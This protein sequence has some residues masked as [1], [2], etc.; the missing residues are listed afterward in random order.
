MANELA[1]KIIQREEKLRSERFNWN[2][3]LQEVSE[4]VLPNRA[5]FTTTI[6]PADNTHHKVFDTT[7]IWANEQLAA[8]LHGF[9]T[10]STQRW[11]KMDLNNEE[12]MEDDEVVNWLA[13]ASDVAYKYIYQ[14]NSNFVSMSHEMYLDLGC[15]GTSVMYIEERPSRLSPLRFHTF[16]LAECVFDEDA[17]GQVNTLYRKFKWSVR[18]I[19][20]KFPDTAPK[21]LHEMVEK[22]QNEEMEI[23]LCVKPTEDSKKQALG[24]AF[25]SVYVLVAEKV[26]LSDKAFYEF[27]FAVPRW[28]KL[29][30]EKMGRSPAMNCLYDI[31]M[32]NEMSKTVL[33]SAQK[34]V[35]PPLM[36]PDEG[37]L[38]PIKTTPGGL[39]YYEA[40]R[41]DRIEPLQTGGDVG[42]GLEM[43]NQRREQILRAFYLDSMKLQKENKEM[44]AY[45]AAQRTEENMR[46]MSPMVS[47]L[48]NEA[49]D[50][51]IGRTISI[52][53]RLQLLPPAPKQIQGLDYRVEYMS[54]V[55]R[56]LKMAGMTGIQR[57]IQV[58]APF[59][60]IKPDAADKIDVDQIID[61][62][63]STLDVPVKLIRTDKEVGDIRQQRAAEQQKQAEAEQ[64]EVMAGA[65]QKGG[66]AMESMAKVKEMSGGGI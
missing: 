35:D 32:I 53:G 30:G 27:P 49:L 65:A 26:I 9:V 11:L 64:A 47:R 45:E 12:L 20:E 44:T 10:P 18:K 62:A 52:L 50:R 6:N 15:L 48:Q 51:I 14:P 43:M 46:A 38:M 59:M 3:T 63:A 4:L 1:E 34:I 13:M 2:Q 19:V 25:D 58:V 22:G 61:Y 42:L 39:N 56:A 21:K 40:G 33:K 60:E 55:T 24:F 16:H 36:L 7:A 29:S 23:I 17:E 41:E 8:G 54:P 57:M 28:S 37:F 66:K 5:A 31:R